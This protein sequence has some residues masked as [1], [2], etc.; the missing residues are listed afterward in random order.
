[1]LVW[2]HPSQCLSSCCL[3]GQLCPSFSAKQQN[4]SP[5]NMILCNTSCHSLFDIQLQLGC[6]LL[7]C[8]KGYIYL[9]LY[10]T[11]YLMQIITVK[12]WSYLR[13]ILVWIFSQALCI[14]E[15]SSQFAHI[16]SLH[17][18]ENTFELFGTYS[19]L[20]HSFSR[21]GPFQHICSQVCMI[22]CRNRTHKLFY[23]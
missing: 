13:N 12:F 21:T 18:K 11:M 1:M 15:I 5:R 22:F 23:H 20:G 9:F 4:N 7:R 3:W 2:K 10:H 6:P 14:L 8:Q 16:E 19:I 17:M